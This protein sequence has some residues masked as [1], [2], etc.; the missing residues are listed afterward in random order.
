MK[1]RR[2]TSVALVLSSAVLLLAFASASGN[3]KPNPARAMSDEMG[4]QCMPVGGS[5]I[6][7]LGSVDQATTMGPATGDLKGSAGG[8]L[9]APPSMS[10]QGVLQ[11][12]VLH[13]WVTESGDT[14]LFSPMGIVET[15]TPVGGGVYGVT[16]EP[17][18][19][20]GGTGKFNGA[21]GTLSLFGAFH[22]TFGM[23]G[24]ISGGQT[25]FRYSG[26]VCLAPLDSH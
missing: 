14:I 26:Q 12:R 9:L 20:T 11:L 1:L 22:L 15:A 8:T 18:Q 21:S 7:N 6:T 10:S 24:Q 5:L 13:H 17:L 4:S 25:V 23:N 3:S 2:I 19:I 16:A